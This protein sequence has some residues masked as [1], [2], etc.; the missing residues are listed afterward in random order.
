[1]K[2]KIFDKSSFLLTNPHKSFQ[3]TNYIPAKINILSIILNNLVICWVIVDE[4]FCILNNF[5][6]QAGFFE[7]KLSK[8]IRDFEITEAQDQPIDGSG[9]KNKKSER[10]EEKRS[11]SRKT[12]DSGHAKEEPSEPGDQNDGDGDQEDRDKKRQEKN[13]DIE[14]DQSEDEES[15]LEEYS[16]D[17]SEDDQPEKQREDIKKARKKI[18]R[19][20]NE[21]SS[22]QEPEEETEE[23]KPKSSRAKAPRRRSKGEESEE[24]AQ[25]S[26]EEKEILHQ[27][28]RAV[29]HSKAYHGSLEPGS[30]IEAF[31][32]EEKKVI[33]RFLHQIGLKGRQVRTRRQ[34]EESE[35]EDQQKSSPVPT[36][37]KGESPEMAKR[38]PKEKE[39]IKEYYHDI[40]KQR[41]GKQPKGSVIEK[42]PEEKQI[43]IRE[44]LH[45]IGGKGPKGRKL[46]G[47]K[48]NRRDVEIEKEEEDQKEQPRT[49]TTTPE[50]KTFSRKSSRGIQEQIKRE[51]ESEAEAEVE[52]PETV[53]PKKRGRPRK[54]SEADEKQKKRKSIEKQQGDVEIKEAMRKVEEKKDKENEQ[55]RSPVFK[56]RVEGDKK[57]K[58]EKR[59]FAERNLNEK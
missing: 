21:E 58:V 6:S 31:T 48:F 14:T 28:Y 57:T 29:G 30:V 44:F 17:Y 23:E 38:S 15:D 55:P 42:Y 16:G 47:K 37:R 51:K 27:Y 25:R 20:R 12:S 43:V 10:S 3:K 9:E 5:D 53:T 26:D 50:K 49:S 32:D 45:E 13:K 46:K 56:V 34:E 22:E 40:G 2:T 4:K 7:T 39:M 36:P 52:Q 11:G 8:K 59:P 54:K 33:R 35:G 18:F 41:G 1:M 19:S 24:M